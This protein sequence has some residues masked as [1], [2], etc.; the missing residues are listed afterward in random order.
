MLGEVWKIGE[1][2]VSPAEN[3]IRRDGE[4]EVRLPPRLID[5]LIFFAKHPNVVVTRAELIA[6]L[7]NRSIVTDQTVTQNI[8]ELRK[9]LRAG[10]S[11]AEAIEYIQTVPKR[12]YRLVAPVELVC[13]AGEQ[14]DAPAE[15]EPV[16][17]AAE[18]NAAEPAEAVA[19]EPEK[20]EAAA[21][22]AESVAAKTAENAEEKPKE[23]E[24]DDGEVQGKKRS[25]LMEFARSF[26]LDEA[27]L[28]F[29]KTAY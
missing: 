6:N 16:A 22:A 12:G 4:P 29:K 23:N 3:T 25:K 17:A 9:C 20:A 21:G 15:A 8:F 1:W 11:R 27:E 18:A 14:L 10:R 19:A 26:W 24:A 13:A 28:G 5:A 7:W 2:T